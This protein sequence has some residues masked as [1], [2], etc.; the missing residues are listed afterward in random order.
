MSIYSKLIRI[1]KHIRHRRKAGGFMIKNHLKVAWRNLIRDRQFTFLNIVGLSIGLACTLFI[2]LWV[3]D[4]RH[5]DKFHENDS[6]L[7]QVMEK[8]QQNNGITVSHRT[9]GPVAEALKQEMPEVENA[10]AVMHY[11]WFPKFMVSADRSKKIKAVGQFADKEFFNVFSYDI[12]Q[13]D[14][15]AVLTDKRAVVIS[16]ELALK[17]FNSTQNII[18]KTLEWEL[19]SFKALVN[20]SGVFRKMPANSSEQFDFV[21]SFETFKEISPPVL[22]WGNNGTNTYVVLKKGTDVKQ[23]N[24]KIAGFIKTK[25]PE[26]GRSIFL[27]SFSG[28]YLYGKYENGIQ[29]GGRIEY[30]HLFTIVAIIILIIAC[31]NFMNLSTAKASRRLKEVGI[32]KVVG[33][34]RSTLIFQYLGESVL[35]VFFSLIISIV[36][37]ALLLPQFSIITS[38][39]IALNWNPG[40]ALTI[41]GIAIL[42]GLLAG[43]YPALYLSGFKPV[44][45]LKGKLKTSIGELW[46]RKGLVISQFSLSVVFIISVVIIYNQLKL[47]QTKNLGYNKDN[48]LYFTK[49]GGIQENTATF[50]S[51]LKNIPGI[52]NASATDHR[53][54][55]GF[56]TTGGVEWPG[57]TPDKE[58]PFEI[59][60]AD[61]DMIEMMSIKIKLG[62]SFSK[63]FGAD[64]SKIIFNEAA[65]D[66]MGLKDPVGKVINLWG[67][68]REIIGVVNN[69]HFESLHKNVKPLFILLEP[70]NAHYIIAKINGGPE[71]ATLDKVKDLYNKYNPGVVFDYKF[72][73]EDYQ[74]LYASEQRVAVLSRYF[75]GLA[76]I[77]SCLGLFGLAAFTAQKRQKEIGIRK[78]VGASVGNIAVMLSKDFVKLVL[79]SVLVAFP[80]AWWAM[81]QWL[82]NFAYR[83]NIGWW[84]FVAAGIAALLIALLTVSFQ[85]IKAAL[86]N[87]VNSLRTE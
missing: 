8:E 59:V 72:L 67:T 36:M 40:F 20:I 68:D 44:A 84:A 2:F 71:K 49:E 80:V 12:I 4:E 78:V 69:F 6:R 76:I 35:M 45:I 83:I 64:S 27:A 1:S 24:N 87:P 43:S 57:K 25:K 81:N 37:V 73:D 75:A 52:L 56:N 13:G 55:G 7:F 31:I 16:D 53:F 58:I 15:N 17:L 61:Y 32:K 39:H 79:I 77:I 51:E 14:K 66:M 42:T 29:S 54:D 9:S 82:E 41:L 65:I 28:N 33:A 19:S 10:T 22:E 26:T 11:S 47:I 21:L 86:A 48:T 74:A 70:K 3:N 18:G 63:I 23:F 85:A 38:K 5:V 50:L 62:R 34:G 46:I 30:V 60:H